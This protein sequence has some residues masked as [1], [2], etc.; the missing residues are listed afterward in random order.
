MWKSNATHLEFNSSQC[1]HL[2]TCVF[3]CC[4]QS[5]NGFYTHH[6]SIHDYTFCQAFNFNWNSVHFLGQIFASYHFIS[7]ANIQQTI[8]NPALTSIHPTTHPVPYLFCTK[9]EHML[10]C[11]LNAVIFCAI[12]YSSFLFLIHS[13]FSA[14]NFQRKCS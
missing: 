5:L 8:L 6:P 11:C 4:K 7:S 12:L 3:D 1:K 9:N 14:S 13:K 2:Y 10:S